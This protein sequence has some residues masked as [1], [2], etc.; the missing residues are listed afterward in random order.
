MARRLSEMRSISRLRVL[1]GFG[2]ATVAIGLLTIVVGIAILRVPARQPAA[3]GAAIQI[4]TRPTEGA[5]YDIAYD[6]LRNRV[7]YPVLRAEGGDY[8]AWIDIKTAETGSVPLPDT[9]YNGFTSQVKVADDGAIWVTEPNLLI[10]YDPSLKSMGSVDLS[11]PADAWI[12]SIAVDGANVIVARNGLVQ[13][14]WVGPGLNLGKTLDVDDQHAGA[15]SMALVAGHLYLTSAYSRVASV[16]SI[17]VASG[18]VQNTPV[19]ATRLSPSGLGLVASGSGSS[20]RLGPANA[21]E[22][23]GTGDDIAV[24]GTLGD[25]AELSTRTGVISAVNQDGASLWSFAFPK[26]STSVINPLGKVVTANVVRHLDAVCID[27]NGDAWVADGTS[28][29]IIQIGP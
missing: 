9:D 29:Q 4:S 15:M 7:W 24:S 18:A 26:L 12:S 3:A 20:Y 14:Q 28:L 27:G 25:I 21:I 16:E 19:T 5:V 22:T 1:G 23:L 6:T 17:D 10:R 13:V 11:G 2:D 8:L